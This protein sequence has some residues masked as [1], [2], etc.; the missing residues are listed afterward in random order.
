[1]QTYSMSIAK[2]LE[3]LTAALNHRTDP[4]PLVCPH[5]GR[6]MRK[7]YIHDMTSCNNTPPPPRQP[8]TSD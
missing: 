5:T 3:I 6:E 7:A 1:M 2:S 8:P 4:G